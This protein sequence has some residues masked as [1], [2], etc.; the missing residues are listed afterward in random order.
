MEIL[1]DAVKIIQNGV[2]VFL[3]KKE[4]KSVYIWKIQRS[5]FFFKKQVGCFFWKKTG[6]SQ[7]CWFF[8]TFWQ[9]MYKCSYQ[10]C[11]LY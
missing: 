5:C 2:F 11:H 1:H 6:F 9:S 7:P 10:K 4:Q 3:L 8:E